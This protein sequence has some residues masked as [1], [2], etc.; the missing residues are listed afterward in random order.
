MV[1]EFAPLS[2]TLRQ[3]SVFAQLIGFGSN[4]SHNN[5]DRL[6][7]MARELASYGATIEQDALFGT[8]RRT[9]FG[10]WARRDFALALHEAATAA[11]GDP[12]RAI[13]VA[14]EVS[15]K[16]SLTFALIGVPDDWSVTELMNRRFDLDTR[17]A[18]IATT[19]SIAGGTDVAVFQEK[20]PARVR[21]N[22]SVTP[23]DEQYVVTGVL[24]SSR[25]SPIAFKGPRR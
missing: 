14:A 16:V 4:L 1:P 20:L 7:K 17:L 21:Q 22:I 2:K 3:E 25:S 10:G 11:N 13:E 23:H 5:H 24:R 9:L 8:F 18:A 6:P 19:C 12:D 15:D